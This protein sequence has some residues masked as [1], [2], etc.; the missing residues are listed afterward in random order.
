[1]VFPSLR[2]LQSKWP[3]LQCGGHHASLMAGPGMSPDSLTPS[4]ICPHMAR[5]SLSSVVITLCRGR[6]VLDQHREV[7]LTPAAPASAEERLR[8][9][10]C[11]GR[12]ACSSWQVPP[13]LRRGARLPVPCLQ[14]PARG[15]VCRSQAGLGGADGGF[16]APCS[17]LLVAPS[18]ARLR[19]PID[20]PY[21]PPAFRFLTKMWHP[22]IYEVGPLGQRAGR[23]M[24]VC[25]DGSG[26]KCQPLS[27][28]GNRCR[29]RSVPGAVNAAN[30]LVTAGLPRWRWPSVSR[31]F[32]ALTL[33]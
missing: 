27:G 1:M 31:A 15:P 33:G 3:L 19:F 30:K 7:L 29:W 5:S 4:P 9:A 14:P 22:N 18:Q 12:R 2:A 16:P 21:S 32:W 24:S 8:G 13:P 28:R 25:C 20:Y 26:W 17:L 23:D 6:R 10:G 11:W